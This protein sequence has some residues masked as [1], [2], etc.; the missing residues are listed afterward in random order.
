MKSWNKVWICM[1]AAALVLTAL[2]ATE[3][4]AAKTVTQASDQNTMKLTDVDKEIQE[5]IKK[6]VRDLSGLSIVEADVNMEG[7]N[8]TITFKDNI[9]NMMMNK[10]TK[11]I[12]FLNLR[13]TFDQLEKAKQDKMIGLLKEPNNKRKYAPKQVD[14]HKSP[15]ETRISMLGE[16][17]AASMTDQDHT[18]Y[19]DFSYKNIDAS[20]RKNAEEALKKFS[21]GG[22]PKLTRAQLHK[23]VSKDPKMKEDSYVWRINGGDEDHWIGL[24][25]GAVTGKIYDVL[26]KKVDVPDKDQA[27]ADLDIKKV[28]AAVESKTKS[29]FNVS[30]GGYEAK[31][32]S[33][34]GSKFIFTKKGSP[35]IEARVDLKGNCYG[36]SLLPENG[37]RN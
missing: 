9:G 37:K 27:Y 19:I 14:L 21:N 22:N 7:V 20:V 16:D 17:F 24:E 10:N 33:K 25:I 31:Q 29:I 35:T 11:E 3:S 36:I 4:Y 12:V 30:L 26:I 5:K 6:E 15:N 34:Y 13:L 32:E 28:K 2:P 1:T 23:F 8:L 18:A